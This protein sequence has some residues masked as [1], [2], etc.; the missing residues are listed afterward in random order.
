MPVRLLIPTPLRPYTAQQAV[1]LAEVAT[2][3]ELLR[4]VTTDYAELRPH[5]YREDGRLRNFVNVYVNDEDIRQL[6]GENT[7]ITASDTLSIV[8]SVA[9]GAPTTLTPV[10]ELPALSNDEVRRY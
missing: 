7:P 6:N 8:P 10:D 3:G 1:V 9:G 5:L 2:V 4:K